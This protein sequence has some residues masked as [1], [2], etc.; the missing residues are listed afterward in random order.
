MRGLTLMSLT[1]ASN[2][3]V[4]SA[5]SLPIMLREV[6]PDLTCGSTGAGTAGYTCPTGM[7]SQPLTSTS[8]H[9][10]MLTLYPSAARN[11][12]SPTGKSSLDSTNQNTVVIA[13]TLPTTVT[14]A[15]AASLLL[16]TRV[17]TMVVLATLEVDYV[18]LPTAML[19][20][21]RPSA[22]LLKGRMPRRT[23]HRRQR[24]TLLGTVARQLITARLRTACSTMDRLAMP[25]RSPREPTLPP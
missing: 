12:E 17:S 18:A 2:L 24:L 20:V 15:M 7:V 3:A 19:C 16:A 23:S 13:A 14:P 11:S 5:S 8:F 21:L 22:A 1:L 4:A 10:I 9:P 25:T 6:S